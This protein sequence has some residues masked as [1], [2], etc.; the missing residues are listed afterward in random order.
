M[1][2]QLVHEDKSYDGFLFGRHYHGSPWYYLPAALLVKTP[3]GALALW[4]AGLAAVLGVRR[5]RAAAPYLLALAGVLFASMLFETRNFGVRYAIV[6][7]VFMAVA[8][9]CVMVIRRRRVRVAIAVLVAFMA[10]SS[11]RTFPYYLPY[12]N[13]AFG[14]PSKTHLRSH[15]SNVDWGQDL[16]RLA[17]RLHA[18]Y[19]GQRVWLVYQGGGRPAYY[20]IDSADPLGVAPDQ[21]HGLLVVSDTR[22]SLAD[23]R[24]TTLLDGATPIGDVGHSITIFLR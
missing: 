17:K 4:L 22:V 7:P 1:R 18:D 3:L 6:V 19:P 11:L 15:D 24:L 10:V 12:S 13:E 20:G 16:G 2:L 23:A 9:G 5:L 14:G 21:V 8:A